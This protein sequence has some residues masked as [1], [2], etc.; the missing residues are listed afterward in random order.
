MKGL[1]K[2]VDNVVSYYVHERV[3]AA[4]MVLQCTFL[5]GQDGKMMPL[6]IVLSLPRAAF[7]WSLILL[8]AQALIILFFSVSLPVGIAVCTVPLVLALYIWWILCPVQRLKLLGYFE[9][10]SFK[11]P[12]ILTRISV[13]FWRYERIPDA[14]GGE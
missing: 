2:D 13:P 3:Y 5:N 6:A 11:L 9:L 14:E 8:A 7:T 4:L 1:S 12:S 10:P